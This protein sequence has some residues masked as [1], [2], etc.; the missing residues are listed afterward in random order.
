MRI[1]DFLSK[2]Y[3]K[4]SKSDDPAYNFGWTAALSARNDTNLKPYRDYLL[5]VF[6]LPEEQLDARFG[7]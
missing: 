1:L 4:R 5:S 3:L 7:A 6:D 2:K